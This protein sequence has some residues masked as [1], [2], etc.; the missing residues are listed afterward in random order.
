MTSEQPTARYA[1]LSV[2]QVLLDW[3]PVVAVIIDGVLRFVR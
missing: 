2:R 1:H 3:V